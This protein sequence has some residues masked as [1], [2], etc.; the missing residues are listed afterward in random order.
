MGFSWHEG[1]V[2]EK[3]ETDSET[4]VITCHRG[5]LGLDVGCVLGINLSVLL[6]CLGNL[7]LDGDVIPARSIQL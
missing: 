5:I 3:A 6:L 2:R 4:S 7:V 1:I